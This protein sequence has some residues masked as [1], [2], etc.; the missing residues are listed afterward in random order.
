MDY[1]SLFK[2]A[3][4]E[5]PER[6]ALVDKNGERNTTYSE[7]DRLS[8]LVSGK[9]KALGFVKGEFILINMGR[10]MEYIASYLGVLKAI[11][12][13]LRGKIVRLGNLMGRHSDGEFQINFNTNAFMNALRGFST[14]GK[15][16]ISHADSRF[17]FDEM[18]LID[19][20]NR[21]GLSI[22]PV[23]DEEY[24]AD[25]YRMLGDSSINSKLQGLM[26]NDRPDLHMV[27]TDNLFTANVLYRLGFS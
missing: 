18:Q 12:E 4:A 11:C 14:I 5:W 17:G 22:K 19:A 15:C 7:L 27:N 1:I 16:P 13:G 25:Y 9:L 6:T 3:V 20:C 26:T 24:Y 21:C 10:R 23:Q 2:Q 8:S